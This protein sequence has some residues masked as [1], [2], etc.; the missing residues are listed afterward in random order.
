MWSG[1]APGNN[2]SAG[3]Q[4]L[5]KARKGNRALRTGLVHMAPA[6]A[7][8]KDTYLS[9]LSHRLAARRGKKRALLAVAHSIVVRAFHMLSRHEPYYELGYATTFTLFLTRERGF[10]KNCMALILHSTVRLILSST[11][12]AYSVYFMFGTKG[13][14][15]KQKNMQ[16][17]GVHCFNFTVMG[18]RR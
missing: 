3:I 10:G 2:A 15:K 12:L 17:E 8:T 18:R 11:V 16:G 5:G 4:P 7:P 6:A 14:E 1:V 9:A 13:A